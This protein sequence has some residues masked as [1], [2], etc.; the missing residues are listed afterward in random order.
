[1]LWL[2]EYT[3]THGLHVPIEVETRTL[4]EVLEVKE[5]IETDRSLR[6]DRVMLDNMTKLDGSREG[7]CALCTA[8]WSSLLLRAQ[9]LGRQFRCGCLTRPALQAVHCWQLRQ[10]VLVTH[11]RRCWFLCIMPTAQCHHVPGRSICK[12]SAE[13]RRKSLGF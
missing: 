9:P 6:V 8:S 12:H 11:A 7:W 13:S 1:M 2:Q 5:L 10:K 4:Q 3:R